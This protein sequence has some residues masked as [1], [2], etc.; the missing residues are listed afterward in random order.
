MVSEVLDTLAYMALLG[1]AALLGTVAGK[2]VVSG[3]FEARDMVK[4]LLYRGQHRD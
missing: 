1:V 4:A 3:V 2:A